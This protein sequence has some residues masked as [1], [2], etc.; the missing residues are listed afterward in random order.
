MQHVAEGERE[1][2]VELADD[3]RAGD[4]VVVRQ[5]K[6]FVEGCFAGAYLLGRVQ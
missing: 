5:D 1:R 4:L 6:L 3:A 2:R